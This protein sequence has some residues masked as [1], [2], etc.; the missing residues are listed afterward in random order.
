MSRP[1]D[2]TLERPGHIYFILVGDFIKIGWSSNFSKRIWHMRTAFPQEPKLIGILAGTQRQ[3]RIVQRHFADCRAR[4]EW[5]KRDQKLLAYIE[6]RT[7][8]GLWTCNDWPE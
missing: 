1:A 3:E 7:E 2:D 8:Q 4:G 5:F 6:E